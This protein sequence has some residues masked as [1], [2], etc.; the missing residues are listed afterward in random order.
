ML[1]LL[2]KTIQDFMR[3]FTS[4][5]ENII[6]LEDSDSDLEFQNEEHEN[7]DEQRTRRPTPFPKNASNNDIIF[8]GSEADSDYDHVSDE[9]SEVVSTGF[10]TKNTVEENEREKEAN[11]DIRD[12][13]S[14][15]ISSND[16]GDQLEYTGEEDTF[17]Y[18]LEDAL[19]VTSYVEAE[20]AIAELNSDELKLN[21]RLERHSSVRN[22][23]RNDRAEESENL[24]EK[25][26]SIDAE[27]RIEERI[28]N[29]QEPQAIQELEVIDEGSQTME[30][31]NENEPGENDLEWNNEDRTLNEQT[32]HSNDV[33]L[34]SYVDQAVKERID[35]LKRLEAE[36]TTA[37]QTKV[38]EETIIETS[39]TVPMERIE[40]G[41]IEVTADTSCA[42]MESEDKEAP[43]EL[44]IV[45]AK[46]LTRNDPYAGYLAPNGRNKRQ[47]T[48]KRKTNNEYMNLKPS[49][50]P[51]E[52]NGVI[53]SYT[54]DTMPSDMLK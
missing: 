21:A 37:M 35:E 44:P 4:N 10:P 12:R 53:V 39:K 34:E 14:S 13:E 33:D 47:K 9:G 29:D 6:I 52:Y 24:E 3:P 7:I 51:K 1:E 16:E 15:S 40:L 11:D 50:L 22:S 5:T 20:A 30:A 17:D 28:I 49:L 2:V 23:G 43:D 45:T 27:S 8:S 31:C 18:Q 19:S 32:N 26:Q 46:T 38:I 54:Q 41:T 48:K 25:L 42:S 36:K